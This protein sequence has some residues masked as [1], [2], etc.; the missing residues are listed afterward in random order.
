[1]K[2]NTKNFYLLQKK[3]QE[4][5]THKL[6]EIGNNFT[7]NELKIFMSHHVY[8]VWDFMSI[9]KCLQNF[10]CPSNYPWKPSKYTRNGIAH[11]INEI[12][13]SE[14]SDYDNNNNYFSHF[15][16]YIMAMSDIG[17]DTS[18]INNFINNIDYSNTKFENSENLNIPK[19]SLE[20]IENT[21]D[22]LYSKSF[23]NTA[24]IFTYGR[25]TTIPDMFS[26]I[27][28]KIDNNNKNYSKLRSYIKRHIEI[29]SSRHGP[30][31]LELFEYSCDSSQ[32]KYDEAILYAIRAIEKRILLWDGV[33]DQILRLN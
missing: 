3:I 25:E 16:L 19:P 24:A 8:A 27:L 9:V 23:C 18:E 31:S 11:L 4:L 15:D 22:C 6:F 1:M 32:E 28:I 5:N 17:A 10:V 33:Y 20:F 14:E 2:K 7:E 30:L 21:F 12:I 29:D 13:L 26:K